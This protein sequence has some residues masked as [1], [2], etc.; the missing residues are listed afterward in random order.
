MFVRNSKIINNFT[1][2][3]RSKP[4]L[5]AARRLQEI[6]E[7]LGIVPY[8]ELKSDWIKGG[9]KLPEYLLRCP[10]KYRSME[11]KFEDLPDSLPST[12][13]GYKFMRVFD[14]GYG[15]VPNSINEIKFREY[16]D[17]DEEEIGISPPRA[18]V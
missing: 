5:Y 18:R 7:N 1:F 17:V 2:W 9:F 4:H 14:D 3:G 6:P 13:D 16:D 8:C 12:R 11:I 15:L 10:P